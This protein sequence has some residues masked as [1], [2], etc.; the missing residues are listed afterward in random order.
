MFLGIKT[1]PA[2]FV[3]RPNEWSPALSEHISLLFNSGMNLESGLKAVAQ[4][5]GGKSILGFRQSFIEVDLSK[6]K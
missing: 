2:L 4:M 3:A 1:Y 6:D 5:F